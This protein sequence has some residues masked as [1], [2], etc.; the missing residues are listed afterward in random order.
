MSHG[1]LV[2]RCE[3][4]VLTFILY[5]IQRI[6]DITAHYQVINIYRYTAL[7]WSRQTLSPSIVH[8]KFDIYVFN[9]SESDSAGCDNNDNEKSFR[10]G[11]KFSESEPVR[12]YWKHPIVSSRT[13]VLITEAELR[14]AE[15]IIFLL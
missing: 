14:C 2:A 13:H 5:A 7:W 15:N 10:I 11:Q 4:N 6:S 12:W 8:T 3:A 9:H 1:S